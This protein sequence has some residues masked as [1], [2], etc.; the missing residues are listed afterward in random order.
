M[1]IA[2]HVLIPAV[3]AVSVFGS[4]TLQTTAPQTTA[5]QTA[6]PQTPR[7]EPAGIK[8]LM[9]HVIPGTRDLSLIV[10]LTDPGVLEMMALQAAPD[11]ATTA[12]L[13]QGRAQARLSAP[14]AVA[15]RTQLKRT[16]DLM[17]TRL[18]AL[19]GVQVQGSTEL[20]INSLFVRTPVEQ[21]DA[22][23]RMPGVK[24]VYFS[25]IQH[26]ALDTAKN[27]VNASGLWNAA[28]V[29]GQANAGN[30]VKIGII[31]TGIDYTHPMFA[32][33]TTTLPAGFPKYDTTADKALTNH[34]VIAAWDFVHSQ[35]GYSTQII[36]DA[37]D[38]VGHGTFNA[39]VS[40]G[41]IVTAPP[42][43]N[44]GAISGMAPG[45]FLGNY[46]VFGTPGINDGATTLGIIA[47]IEQAVSDGMNVVSLSLGG[48]DWVPPSEDP[49][50]TAIH[51][52]TAAGVVVVV[53]AG[54]EGNDPHT[55]ASPGTSPDAITV[56]AVW[57]SRA[58][59][60]GLHVTGPG[61]VPSNLQSVSYVIGTGPTIS[62]A[63]PTAPVV[64]VASLDGTGLAC[65]ALP[66]GTLTAKIA[67]IARGQCTFL[68]KATNAS[69]AGARAV[70]V[71]DNVP[72][73]P[74]FGMGGLSSSGPPAVM[75]SY[76]D[77][78]N[79]KTFL[80]A[81]PGGTASIDISN[82]VKS[83]PTTPAILASFSGRGPSADFGI[84]PDLS[85]VGVNV[86]SATE[87]T[88]TAGGM[89][90]ATR[91]SYGDGTSF[92]TP[93]VAGAAAGIMQLF[94]NL[95]AAQ[96]KSA[97]VNTASQTVT[98]DGTTPATVTQT[99]AGLLNMGNAAT[100]GAVFSPVSLNFGVQSYSGRKTLTRSLTITNISGSTD[101]YTISAQTQTGPALILSTSS[102]GPVASGAQNA[103]TVNVTIQ[104]TAPATGGFQGYITV[105]SA[106]TG[107]TY[108]IPYWAGLYVPDSSRVLTVSQS[109]TGQN[110]FSNLKDAL[111]A[112]NPGN[113]IEIADTQTYTLASSLDSTTLPS[114]MISTNAQGLPLHGITIRAAAGQSPVL[115]GSSA[116]AY[117]DLQVV[118][119]QGVLIQGLTING[120]ETGI[121]IW[122]PSTSVPTSVTIDHC[123]LT[124]QAASSYS[125]GVYM[126]NGGD[127]SIT[128]ST[129]TG[130][131][132]QAVGAFGG[133]LT[134]SGSTVQGNSSDGIDAT[135]VNLDLLNSTI[136]AN[137]G[138]GINTQNCSGTIAKNTI[139]NNTDP[140]VGDGLEMWDGA[141]TIT[142]NIFTGNG[143]SGIFLSSA[144]GLTMG[145]TGLIE[146]NT[147]QLNA[148][149][150]IQSWQSQNIQI[151]GNFIAVCGSG[152]VAPS[153]TITGS[154]TPNTTTAILVN[155]I[156]VGSTTPSYYPGFTDPGWG[157]GVY[158]ADASVVSLVNN[159]IYNNQV[160][161]IVKTSSST[162]TVQNTI[163]YS[164]TKGDQSGLSATNTL[165]SF[166]GDGSITG[167]SNL[168][169]NPNFNNPAGNDFSLA[170]GSSAIEKGNNTAANLPFLDY[171]GQF[172]VA[173][174]GQLPGT[175]TVD[176]GAIEY[177]SSY[178][179]VFPMLASGTVSGTGTGLDNSSFT[180]AFAAVN[181][182]TSSATAATFTAYDSTGN[183]FSGQTPNNTIASIAPEAH[184]ASL[185]YQLFS[186]LPGVTKLGAVLA[187]SLQK[188][189]GFFL[190][191]D[192]AF[193][194]LADGVDVSADTYTDFYFM[195]YESDSSGQATYQ[196][197]NPGVNAAN[198]TAIAYDYSGNLLGNPISATIQPK[199]QYSFSFISTASSSGYVHVTS[200]QPVSG[201]E[202]FGNSAEI[203]ALR[204]A[205]AGT[206]TRIF[207]PHFAVNQGYTSLIGV[208]NTSAVIANLTLTAYED[209]GSI[210]GTPV[211]RHV[212]GNGQLLESA[213]S[214]FGLG[215]GGII[216]GYIIAT[217]DQPGIT[218]FSAFNYTSGSISS[219]SAVPSESVPQPMLIFSHIA[220]L[221][222][223]GTPN[224]PYLTG[225][226]LLNPYGTQVGYLMKVFD[227]SGNEVG[228]MTDILG[229]Y[230]KVS[231]LLSW[232]TPGA[233][234]FTSSDSTFQ[235]GSG[236]IE[237]TALDPTTGSA[238]YQ[239]LG[240]EMFFTLSQ[241]QLAAVMAQFPN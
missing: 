54:N 6:V 194:H 16:R 196:I 124:N 9:R 121:D 34:K 176:M 71:Y 87:N 232:S 128:N 48:L 3:L 154:P 204:A 69:S 163:V 184:F 42:D 134:V 23:R 136:T 137:L 234:F 62:S 185:D 158:A 229:P 220:N 233:G 143:S 75:I 174:A 147:F 95:T 123:T 52:A 67:L 166:I 28:G 237:V 179:M 110:A 207:F 151:V 85:A 122:Q 126:E 178:P 211:Q 241:S 144:T 14:E 130:A 53:A 138:T 98:I 102:T 90:S 230:Q 240:F 215:S 165:Y 181:P 169:G 200:T 21:Y 205:P 56:G 228:E 12:A 227:G 218:G 159:T 236:H 175:G 115:D 129:I 73:D 127:V 57:N 88:Y 45:A 140:N 170:A 13:G 15:Y 199:A 27:V 125:A 86:Y 238:G 206:E 149:Y 10:E 116:S 22:I 96:V 111:A 63:I 11:T 68:I 83:V 37:R 101:Q 150:G 209:N 5:L 139:S 50:V 20:V 224:D 112:A 119:A 84:K 26:M 18:G 47:A 212:N 55:V 135:N 76:S 195:R 91:Y 49:E 216:T 202:I 36:N 131:A 217:S 226:A 104:A 173:S 172:R 186:Y 33:T 223:S 4:G 113:V 94:P 105:Q 78:L 192:P 32:D 148:Q 97:I 109:A 160:R 182:S 231:K 25:R 82:V 66:S 155:N 92:S 141:M 60:P 118:G 146:R 61:S 51:N 100:A 189:V 39:G 171:N 72:G 58:L 183:P 38:E 44:V 145:A 235:L 214:L 213:S 201:L 79:L 133:R 190:M 74:P 1:R 93:M 107:M 180:T 103:V 239:L 80:A 188:L 210:L 153:Y 31:D 117:A 162:T 161:G 142:G 19:N 120:G 222:P 164:N 70:I 35:Y 193:Q 99:G 106:Q 65:A 59:G 191:F 77:A 157:S 177:G 24:K 8:A 40:A 132:Y 46:K 89:Y 114:I 198:I 203:A 187:S 17:T 197:F 208:V 167:G 225:I 41:K 81:N 7:R 108:A 152:F 64:D 219:V 168:K 30:G 29:G 221:W 156:I 2:I 43:A